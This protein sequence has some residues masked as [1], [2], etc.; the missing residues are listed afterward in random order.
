MAR[1]PT[2]WSTCSSATLSLAQRRDKS[3]CSGHV[4]DVTCPRE[5][6]VFFIM[7]FPPL[8][9]QGP[10]WKCPRQSTPLSF[11][12]GRTKGQ[13][14]K[15]FLS[16]KESWA[17]PPPRTTKVQWESTTSTEPWTS[18][19]QGRKETNYLLS[20]CTLKKTQEDSEDPA[21]H[22]IKSQMIDIISTESRFC[23][24]QWWTPATFPWKCVSISLD[25]YTYWELTPC[26]LKLLF[27]ALFMNFQE[28]CSVNFAHG[29]HKRRK[30]SMLPR[31]PCFI[32]SLN[33][34]LA[35]R[36]WMMIWMTS[37]W[38]CNKAFPSKEDE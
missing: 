34:S 25:V 17:A 19:R 23:E 13:C 38:T 1:P 3:S 22:Y 8:T 7:F 11:G 28:T 37:G 35:W 16:T 21:I 10:S 29:L 26:L 30:H 15:K 2:S 36:A 4:Q 32:D 6:E 12:I 14:G 31:W 33:G 5:R 18:G 24:L 20:I 27:G 9:C